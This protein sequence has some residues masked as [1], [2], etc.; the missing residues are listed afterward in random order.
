MLSRP[1]TLIYN[2]LTKKIKEQTTL[3]LK[4]EINPYDI[5]KL[6]KFLKHSK[7]DINLEF[8]SNVTEILNR[9][10]LVVV[11]DKIYQKEYFDQTTYNEYLMRYST[12]KVI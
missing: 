7:H 4:Y 8:I 3:I 10:K 9:I 1:E 2:F 11:E 12:I 5:R 6:L